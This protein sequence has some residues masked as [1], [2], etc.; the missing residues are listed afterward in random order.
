M[1]YEALREAEAGNL[2]R[3]NRSA[4]PPNT[5]SA[6]ELGSGV[7]TGSLDAPRSSGAVE[8]G[9]VKS[10]GAGSNRAVEDKTGLGRGGEY[11]VVLEKRHKLLGSGRS[12]HGID[13]AGEIERAARS[14]QTRDV[15]T[16]RNSDVEDRQLPGSVRD[17]VV[18]LKQRA[19]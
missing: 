10:A 14:G 1:G 11:P 13:G 6:S 17:R 9:H 8:K 18:V 7:T 3:Q 2:F 15:D 19:N 5:H 12:I 4:A 16:G